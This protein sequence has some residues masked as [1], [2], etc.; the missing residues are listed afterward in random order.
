MEGIGDVPRGLTPLFRDR[1]V[2]A[3]VPCSLEVSGSRREAQR[4]L[5]KLRLPEPWT[6]WI[7]RP[8]LKQAQFFAKIFSFYIE[9]IV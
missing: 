1:A 9:N 7:P 2:I 3:P 5:G 6:R 4:V 8:G